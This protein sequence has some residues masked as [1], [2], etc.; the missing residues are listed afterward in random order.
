MVD[1]PVCMC[2]CVC[3]CVCCVGV[4]RVW[5]YCRKPMLGWREGGNSTPFTCLPVYALDLET[6]CH[7]RVDRYGYLWMM[8]GSRRNLSLRQGPKGQAV[9]IDDGRQAGKK[10][11][12]FCFV[13]QCLGDMI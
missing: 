2:V 9:E 1:L 3:V 11:S 8:P 13:F 10:E 6:G 7:L 5:D 4:G 12:V